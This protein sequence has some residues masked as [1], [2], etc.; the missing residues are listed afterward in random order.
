MFQYILLYVSF[1]C[2]VPLLLLLLLLSVMSS[3]AGANKIRK[4][5]G[6][7]RRARVRYCTHTCMHAHPHRWTSFVPSPNKTWSY[8]FCC[9]IAAT[10]CKAYDVKQVN[11]GSRQ[12]STEERKREQ[13]KFIFNY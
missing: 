5:V 3:A 10:T 7:N 4:R 2:A 8:G 9:R 12:R 13:V 11:C 1:A 6:Y